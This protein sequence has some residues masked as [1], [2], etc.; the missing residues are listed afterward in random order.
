MNEQRKL[1]NLAVVSTLSPTDRV[2]ILYDAANAANASAKTT[3]VSTLRLMSS[4][5]PANSTAN[6][7]PGSTAY[8]AG[9]VYVCVAPNTWK[10]TTLTTW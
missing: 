8:D 9:Y 2:L 4:V 3:N 7:V 10:R 5:V 6:G 1:S